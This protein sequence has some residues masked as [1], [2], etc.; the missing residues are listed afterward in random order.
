[1]GVTLAQ[2]EAS[3]MLQKCTQ[4]QLH[5][6]TYYIM[7]NWVSIFRRIFNWRLMNLTTGEVSSTYV[8]AHLHY[9][10]APS[11]EVLDNS[12]VE[13]TT[14]LPPYIAHP[15]FDELVEVGYHIQEFRPNFTEYEAFQ[16]YSPVAPDDADVATSNGN[17]I[18]MVN[19]EQSAQ[20]S[21][22]SS[23]DHPTVEENDD[24]GQLTHN[25]K[26]TATKQAD[27]LSK[28]LEKCNIVQNQIDKKLSIYF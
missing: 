4:L 1:M 26:A 5:N 22:L 2:K 10:S 23:N 20:D 9:S 18:L 17:V 15:S 6:M 25:T 3:I 27:T 12:E 13:I 11:S 8:L 28:L 24:V 7:P 14:F 21:I 16:L 19:Q